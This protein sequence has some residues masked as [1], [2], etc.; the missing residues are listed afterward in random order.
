ML[1]FAI[2]STP[3]MSYRAEKGTKYV[4]NNLPPPGWKPV[5]IEHPQLPPESQM[6]SRDLYLESIKGGESLKWNDSQM[7]KGM[8][9]VLCEAHSH[10]ASLFIL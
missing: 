1:F 10:F 5:V 9:E 6:V 8:E 3:K 7:A 2:N 4:A